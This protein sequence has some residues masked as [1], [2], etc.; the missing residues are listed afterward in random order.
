MNDKTLLRTQVKEE[1][2][3]LSDPLY[4]DFSGQIATRLY[5]DEDWKQAGMI[6]VTISRR[7][8]VDT[9]QIIR[10]AW[11]QGKQVVV[12]KC[13]PKA[14]KM[15]FYSISEFSQLTST[16][17]GLSEP[18]EAVTQKVA[19]EQID[20]LI[21][22]GLAYTK[23]GY[24]IGFGGGYYDRYLANF[25]GKTVSLAFDLQII[26]DF[27]VEQHDIPVAKIITTEKVILCK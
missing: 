25:T 1:L 9:L 7:P 5:N 8:E 27:T 14:K 19:S 15:T 21:V 10:K 3:K 23:N 26:P 17:F 22:P 20:L 4:E 18:I 13:F 11:E 12:P 24:R 6:G 16:F 2:S